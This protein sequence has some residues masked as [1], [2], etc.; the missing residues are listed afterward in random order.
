MREINEPE[1]PINHRVAERDKR[2]DGAERQAVDELLEK[3][4]Q[5][6]LIVGG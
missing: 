1:N 6:E 4:S 2:D 5:K 3:F